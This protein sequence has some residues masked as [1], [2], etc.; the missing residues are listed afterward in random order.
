MAK[1]DL[2]GWKGI[3]PNRGKFV[4]ADDGLQYVFDQIGI[5]AF[6]HEAPDAAMFLE[7]LEDWYFSGNWIE[8]YEEDEYG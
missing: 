7:E 4:E 6:N 2:K 5:M 1:G 3:G 8:V